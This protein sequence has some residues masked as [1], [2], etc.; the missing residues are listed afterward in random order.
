MEIGLVKPVA[1]EDEMRSS[2]LDYAMSVI[3]SRALPDVRDGLKPVQRRILYA[4][5]GL[6]LR[7]ASAHKKSARI[8]GE[9]LGKYHPHGDASIYSAMV[10]MA[11]D[12]S[13][14]HV[15]VD[16]QG[17]FGS[18]DNDPPAA[19]RYTE[20][21]LAGI[22]EEML[23]DIDK[24]TVDFTSN[25][26]DSLK[27]P[28]VLPARL[29]NL[30]V[31]GSVGIAVG[32]ATNI[33]PHNLG[34]VCNAI[35][36]LIENPEA[37]AEELT[38]FVKG[39]DSPTG[40]ICLGG[41]A[42]RDAYITGR[43]KIVTRAK[44]SEE[45]AEGGRYQ[46][47]VTEL[48]Y[49]TNKAA[50]VEKIAELAK[51]RNIE[52]ISE[53][54]DESDR[55]GVRIVIELRR[56]AQPKRICNNLYKYTPMQS[57]FFINM[58]ALVDGQPKLINL[59]EALNCYI[60]FRCGVIS[61][62][63]QFELQKAKSRAHILEGFRIALD[64]LT[65]V[66]NTIRHSETVESARDKLMGDFGL[67]QVQVQSILDMQLR[68]L[69]RLERKKVVD[70]Y[71][72]VVRTIAYLEDLLANPRKILFLV[73]EDVQQLKSKYGD[74][75]RTLISEAEAVEFREEDLITHENVV[76]TLSKQG[77]IKRIPTKTYRLQHRGGKGIIGMATREADVVERLLVADT[78]DILLLFT[79]RG[80]VFKLKCYDIPQDLS[81]TSKG[82]ALANLLAMD[83]GERVTALVGLESLVSPEVFLLMVT[84]RGR[85]KKTS[86][87][88]F[89]SVR[90]CGLIAVKLGSK[91]ELVTACKV[92]DT[93]EVM[94]VS[95]RGQAVKF[96]VKPLRVASR[97]SGGV[98]GIR[99]SAD[100]RVVEMGVIFPNA[101][102]LTVTEMGFG[103]RTRERNYPLQARGGKGVRAHKIAEKTGNVV[104][105]KLIPPSQ[106][107]MIISSEGIIVRIPI[108]EE[109]PLHGR[110]TQ[111]VHLKKLDPGDRVAAVAFLLQ[112]GVEEP[113]K[114]G[115]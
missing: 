105:A 115:K 77:Y 87:S 82:V 81:R 114:A 72:E 5:D 97:T 86:L 33:P 102:L 13:M 63:S 42:I 66:I 41:E 22:A 111:G 29:P 89:S 24:D 73:K 25:F 4:M 37:T 54:R 12:F 110:A 48:P 9:V 19:M 59:R 20:V 57:A 103:K 100:D 34:E 47:I 99:L 35:V 64:H 40:G 79:N 3:V 10:R 96:L 36:H 78:H 109:I 44:I 31:N 8:V 69:A 62:R 17:N 92:M 68:R 71:A 107:L 55:Q 51:E 2:Y 94:L 90:R 61:R 27:E 30:L 108:D 45:G 80:K 21:R 106:Q 75:R 65:E 76:V 101:Q 91:E 49:Q 50:L 98:R 74:P 60:D 56:G 7:H 26:D 38:Q 112:E 58:V 6:G 18:L 104:A 85:V 14:R 84:S 46:I 88:K 15:L 53:V 32:M 113:Q 39:P 95:Q 70:E 28:S 1:I 23:V 83:S 52:G 67:S 11:Q 93:D 43:G 16:G